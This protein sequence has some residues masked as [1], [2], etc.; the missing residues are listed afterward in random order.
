MQVDS[1]ELQ[2]MQPFPQLFAAAGG[3]GTYLTDSCSPTSPLERMQTEE[4]S[5]V[6]TDCPFHS[7][8]YEDDFESSLPL[9]ISV[10]CRLA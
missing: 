2:G 8:S 6:S 7:I 1:L 4:I 10:V 3:S 9:H 5:E